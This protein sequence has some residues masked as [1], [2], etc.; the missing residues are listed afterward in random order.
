VFVRLN[1]FDN[2]NGSDGGIV[3]QLAEK[4]PNEGGTIH[5]SD[6]SGDAFMGFVNLE[7]QLTPNV[8][9]RWL[10]L[11][12]AIPDQDTQSGRSYVS[13]YRVCRGAC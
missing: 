7:V 2:N 6:S 5:D 9:T 1:G 4:Y 11:Y 12:V 10:F 13:G 3:L 8:E